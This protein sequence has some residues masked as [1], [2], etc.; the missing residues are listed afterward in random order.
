MAFELDLAG[1]EAW[2]AGDILPAGTYTVEV[3]DSEEGKSSGG[4]PQIEL[5]LRCIAGQYDGGTIKDWV[6]VIPSTAGKVKQ[7]LAAFGVEGLDGTVKFEASDLKGKRANIVVRE[8]PYDGKLKSRV[9]AYEPAA[10]V[11]SP[12]AT[13]NGSDAKAD[14]DDLPF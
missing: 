8:E 1:V 12:T 11:S 6:V 13:T 2:E 9:K 7:I 14:D 4:H 10:A 5:D 3:T